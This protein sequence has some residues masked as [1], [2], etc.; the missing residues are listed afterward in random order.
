[1]NDLAAR[2]DGKIPLTLY[3]QLFRNDEGVTPHPRAVGLTYT[4]QWGELGAMWRYLDYEFKDGR[5]ENLTTNGPMIGAK[6]R[7]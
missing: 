3:F 6:F 5:L 1:M 7:W 2:L 4:F